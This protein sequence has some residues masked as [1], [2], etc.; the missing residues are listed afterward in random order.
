MNF[1]LW[2]GRAPS[3]PP[4][5]PSHRT[6][7]TTSR[8]SHRLE[9]LLVV[10]DYPCENKQR[11]G[12]NADGGYVTAQLDGHYDS[13]V[14]C[15]V[16]DE[17]SFSKCFLQLHSYLT[18]D[19]C[20]AFDGTI[21]DYPWHFVRDITFVRKNIGGTSSPHISDLTEILGPRVDSFVSMDIEGGEWDWLDTATEETLGCIKQLVL[22][23]H[24]LGGNGWGAPLEKKERC[25]KKL[26]GTHSI[27]HAHG[28]NFSG[29]THGIPDVLELTLVRNDCLD[30][31][32]TRNASALPAPGLDFPN[33]CRRPDIGLNRPPFV[34]QSST[35]QD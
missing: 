3:R 34:F 6:Q 21:R 30:A 14:S 22:E 26:I 19:N 9:P 29:V 2:P 23:T 11:H 7:E 4:S 8:T 17:E 27:V 24:G 10:R 25:L 31:P 15:G 35:P 12:S 5:R 16:A 13:Y 28:N 18:K 33:N 32:F 1:S 20:F